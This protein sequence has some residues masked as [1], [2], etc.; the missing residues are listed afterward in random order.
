VLIQ[1]GQSGR[2][3]RFA[4]RWGELVFCAYKNIEL[5]RANYKEL[6]DEVVKV[7]RDPDSIAICPAVY[8]IVGETSAIAKEK[9]AL[10]DSMAQPI[11]QL[12]LLSEGLNFDFGSKPLDEPFTDAELKSISGL[13]ALRDRVVQ[14]KGDKKPTVR[15]F[16]EITGRGT[17]AEHPVICGSPTEVVDQMEAW[18]KAPACDGFV[19]AATS[20]PGTY[21]DFVRLVV[22]E[23][24]RR[25]L[26]HRDY[27]GS[28]LRENLGLPMAEPGDW[29]R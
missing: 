3:K 26:Y 4:A 12:A 9:L 15:D 17:L 5:G 18:F 21:E 23:L 13:Q 24:Q 14:V 7:G 8:I 29:K 25:G 11:D 16:M 1:A 19:L 2:G 6:K 22:P 20:I 27:A 28:T 10:A